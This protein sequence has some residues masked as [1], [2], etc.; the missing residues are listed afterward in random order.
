M[1]YTA[2][3]S[4]STR[5]TLLKTVDSSR[6]KINEKI[7]GVTSPDLC[8]PCKD[9]NSSAEKL[10]FSIFCLESNRQLPEKG[11]SPPPLPPLFSQTFAHTFRHILHRS[12]HRPF[13][14]LFLKLVSPFD[15]VFAFFLPPSIAHPPSPLRLLAC[16]RFGFDC[17]HLPPSE[18]SEK[19]GD[20]TPPPAPSVSERSLS[21]VVHPHL[22]Y[23][24]CF[25]P[26]HL[27]P[28]CAR[29]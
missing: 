15:C 7:T 22:P 16:D 3:C 27:P 8:M 17:V 12:V 9:H 24:Y 11:A 25:D 18:M 13:P 23:Y 6:C 4:T 21:N 19:K 10:I 1:K 29:G 5:L 20:T 26:H 14:S 28:Y 2:R